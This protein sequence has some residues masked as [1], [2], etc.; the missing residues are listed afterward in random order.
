MVA[1]VMQPL[2]GIDFLSHFCLLDALMS[3]S[4]AQAASSLIPSIKTISSCTL[5]DS[6]FAEFPD[7]T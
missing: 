2:I 7:L 6:L 3:S 4:F 5:I 1:N